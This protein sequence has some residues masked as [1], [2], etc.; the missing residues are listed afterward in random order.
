MNLLGIGMLIVGI[1][2]ANVASLR[3]LLYI[4]PSWN[5]VLRQI[6]F[7]LILIR[8]GIGIEIEVLKK[9]WVRGGYSAIF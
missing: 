8:C 5:E 6:A 9:S 7:V 4:H 3:L 1:I 2:V